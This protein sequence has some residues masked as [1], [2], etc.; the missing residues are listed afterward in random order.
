MKARLTAVLLPLLLIALSC[1]GNGEPVET[2]EEQ[3]A[4]VPMMS[5][6]PV[7]SIGIEMGDTCYVLGAVEGVAYGPDGNIAILDCAMSSIR[8]YS[9]EGEF[10]R[11]ISQRGNGPGEL[12]SVAFLGISE[13]GLISM[14][15][16]GSEV[17][18]IH[19]FD[20]DTGEW[21]GSE[22][23]L[24]TPPTCIEGAEDSSY[25][26][27]DMEVDV[28]TGEPMILVSVS[29]YVT[30]ADDPVATYIEEVVPFD[31]VD[32]ASMIE[33][34][35]Y[36]YE[37]AA[38]FNGNVYIAKRSSEDSDVIIFGQDGLETGRIHLDLEPVL[39]TDEELEMERLI[40]TAKA[41]AMDMQELPPLEIDP[42]KSLISG[43]EVDGDG[44]IWIQY[45]GAV[46]PTFGVYSPAGELQFEAMV[47]GEPADGVSWRFYIDEH[48][49][50]AYAEDPASGFQKVYILELQ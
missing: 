4:D 14:A 30:G 19:H 5:L 24:G 42:Y 44:N 39:R 7:D 40:L 12:Q 49:M 13:A 38:D 46:V 29:K 31:P 25:V 43:L 10:I 26:R 41:I 50:L 18:G 23:T 20:Y 36:G 32:M 21:L 22:S 8:I 33:L 35:W 2:A 48:G 47:S 15:G 45:G 11:Q 6:V 28:S 1:G 34:V 37:I 27:K 3:T 16:E 17:L 9:P